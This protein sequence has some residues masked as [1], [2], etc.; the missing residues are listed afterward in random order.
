MD[1]LGRR[2]RQGVR[3]SMVGAL[4]AEPPAGA[5]SGLGFAGTR[6]SRGRQ[7]PLIARRR[8]PDCLD[9]QA[10]SGGLLREQ[11]PKPCLSWKRQG[12]CVSE[13]LGPSVI[14]K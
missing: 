9:T 7:V 12:F 8:G 11:A 10:G 13:R 5:R 6:P 4:Q 1:W 14:K 2:C 3:G